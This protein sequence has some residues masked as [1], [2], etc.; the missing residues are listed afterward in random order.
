MAVHRKQQNRDGDPEDYDFVEPLPEEYT[1]S[2]C[3]DV[4]K[5]PHLTTC[6]GKHFCKGCIERVVN[7]E[8]PCPLCNQA[9]FLAVIDK[10]VERRVLSLKVRCPNKELGCN[11]VGE[12]RDR[13]G[14]LDLQKGQCEHRHINC[15]NSCGDRVPKAELDNHLTDSCS[16]RKVICQYC[17]QYSTFGEIEDHNRSCVEFPVKCPNGCSDSEIPRGSLPQHLLQCPFQPVP[18]EFEGIGCTTQVR[19]NE[20]AL[21]ME[22]ASQV[23]LGQMS[24]FCIDLMR[25]LQEKDSET[26]ELKR[27]LQEKDQE[28]AQLRDALRKLQVDFQSQL[29]VQQDLFR[30]KLQERS[31]QLETLELHVQTQD[32]QH[33]QVEKLSHR[34]LILETLVNVPPYYFT[35]TNFA[36]HKRGTTQWMCPAF[37]NELGGYKMALEISAYGEG[38][39]K[40]THVSVYIRIMR[41][42]YDDLLRWP[43]KASVTIQLISQLNDAHYEMT[44]P[45]YEWTRVREGVVGVGWGWDRFVAHSDLEFNTQRRT[46]YLRNDRLNFRVICVD[47]SMTRSL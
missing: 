13:Q 2:V 15:P 26:A 27:S 20:M 7:D 28:M 43:L 35:M 30:S 25:G 17:N 10:G 21:H 11:W 40:G 18:C 44:T 31:D 23:H 3:L 47:K 1:C 46:E 38:A 8:N 39:G 6:C 33:E 9:G 19:R 16:K 32:D 45:V 12:M 29:Q 24:R 34:V 4:L 14:H 22:R 42:E 5:E 41:G 36:L 37:H